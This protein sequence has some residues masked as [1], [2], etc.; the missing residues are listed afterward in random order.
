MKYLIFGAG[1]IG[2]T[3]AWLLSQKNDV[4]ILVK[5][6]HSTSLSKGITMLVKDLRKQALNY[7]TIQFS[8][9]C[10]TEIREQY[11]VI[12]VAV[13]RCQLKDVLPLLAEKQNHTKYFAFM[14]NN[15]N[16][17]RE[18][19]QYISKERYF[20]AFPSSVGG[21][22]DERGVEVIIFDEA[23][24]LGG[25]CENAIAMMKKDL[26]KVGIKTKVDKNIF[27]WL[28]VHYLQQSITA[29]AVLESGDFETFVKDYNAIKKIVKAFREGI[30][31]C[32]L[33]GVKTNRIFPANL[34]Q[35]P[36]GI[37][38]RTMQKMFLEINTI[39]MVNNHMKK[40]L[41][42]WI[43]GYKEVLYDGISSGLSMTV[44]KSYETAVEEYL[45][46]DKEQNATFSTCLGSGRRDK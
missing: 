19:E 14:Q 46:K 4:D 32:R 10:I 37:V 8:L 9:K 41:V 23:T 3:Y 12:L 36:L 30:E 34:F 27:D 28:K 6:E 16:I 42:E 33:Q 18:V 39:E 44:W 1:T 5:P 26:T 11:D 29:G 2:I 24:R 45:R 20:I 38:A 22:R 7:E 17:K 40:G 25:Q 31:V 15:W 13:N 43:A 35:L 21:G